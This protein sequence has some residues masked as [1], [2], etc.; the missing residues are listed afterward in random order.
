MDNLT[1]IVSGRYHSFVRSNYQKTKA[2]YLPITGI[3][4]EI[5]LNIYT[6]NYTEKQR[7]R[8]TENN[9]Y[10]KLEVINQYLRSELP[11]KV[12]ISEPNINKPQDPHILITGFSDSVSI[13]L[14]LRLTGELCTLAFL[15]MSGLNSDRALF[16]KEMQRGFYK[17]VVLNNGNIFNSAY[18]LVK[19]GDGRPDTTVHSNLPCILKKL[20][21]AIN[22][23]Q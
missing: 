19:G 8:I 17:D 2:E 18:L 16:E 4:R 9:I 12:R 1:N 15:P 23:V 5:A 3:D 11:S 20:E 10:E 21:K 14:K 6:G 22:Q 13:V 7:Q